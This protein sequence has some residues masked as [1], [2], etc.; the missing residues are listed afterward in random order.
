MKTRIFRC[1]FVN[2]RQ[3]SVHP[4]NAVTNDNAYISY[5]ASSALYFENLGHKRF[6][7]VVPKYT[8]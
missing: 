5:L 8:S 1:V 4:N 2:R 7:W 3:F 6:P